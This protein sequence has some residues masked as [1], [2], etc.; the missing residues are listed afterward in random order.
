MRS[1]FLRLP[2]IIG[3]N[4]PIPCGKSTWWAGV[5]SGR[6]PPPCKSGRMTFW[7]RDDIGELLELIARGLDWRNRGGGSIA[8]GAQTHHDGYSFEGK[9]SMSG[10]QK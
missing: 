7:H 10:D 9:Q 2:S 5:K 3:P 6:F 8:A 4:G 1:G